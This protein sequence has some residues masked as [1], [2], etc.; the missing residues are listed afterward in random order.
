MSANKP[1]KIY[2]LDNGVTITPCEL[3]KKLR[4]SV[5]AARCRLDKFTD[6]VSVF[7]VVGANRPKRTYKC[8]FFKLC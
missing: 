5:P 2:T 8:N 3:A 7:R 1:Q 4:V 6:P